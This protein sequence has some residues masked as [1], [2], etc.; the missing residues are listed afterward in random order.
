L[1]R[2]EPATRSPSAAEVAVEPAEVGDA[3]AILTLQRLAYQ[4]EAALYD[5]WA[6]PPLTQTLDQI[7]AEF[8]THLFLKA[9]AGNGEIIGS[10]RA[11][12]DGAG[13]AHIGRLIVSPDCQGRGIGT[14]LMH[15][16]EEALPDAARFELFTGSK[17]EGNLRLY[18]RL[19]YRE[20]RRE[21]ATPDLTF[22]FLEKRRVAEQA[23]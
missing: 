17:S 8:A 15:A 22:V 14:R 11:R 9:V 23:V 6:I 18:Q 20:F 4:S 3:A 12:V 10:A 2:N 5:D 19:G 7:T 21:R 16:I 1:N 13:T